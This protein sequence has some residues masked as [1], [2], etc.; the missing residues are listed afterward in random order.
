MSRNRC[1]PALQSHCTCHWCGLVLLDL[2]RH[3]CWKILW[4]KMVSLRRQ[5]GLTFSKFFVC[6]IQLTQMIFY[7]WAFSRVERSNLLIDSNWCI[8][9]REH[10][11]HQKYPHSN[12]PSWL[13]HVRLIKVKWI[14]LWHWGRIFPMA[15]FS[16]SLNQRQWFYL[17]QSLVVSLP[18]SEANS[19]FLLD[20]CWLLL[21]WIEGTLVVLEDA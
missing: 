18:V 11:S 13:L 2:A 20:L 19:L 5:E 15:P 6:L 17:W 4:Q 10:F 21:H 14:D 12:W 8:K 9:S 1:Y 3:S 16:L 7:R